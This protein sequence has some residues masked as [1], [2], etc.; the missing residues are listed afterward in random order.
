MNPQTPVSQET[1]TRPVSYAALLA[2]HTALIAEHEDYLPQYVQWLTRFLNGKQYANRPELVRTIH[3]QAT[4]NAIV[5]W[6]VDFDAALP[7]KGVHN[8]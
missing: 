8:G 5:E 3:L 4:Q 2:L 7:Q 1:E 6:M